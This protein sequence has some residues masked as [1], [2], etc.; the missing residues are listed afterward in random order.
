MKGFAEPAATPK[1]I[2]SAKIKRTKIREL[3]QYN[4]YDHKNWSSFPRV[5]FRAKLLSIL[6]IVSAHLRLAP[7]LPVVLEGLCG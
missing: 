7:P 1:M 4:L 3:I 6:I 5:R 2:M